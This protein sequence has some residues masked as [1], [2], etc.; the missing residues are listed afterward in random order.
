[1]SR[2]TRLSEQI[3]GNAFR[4]FVRGRISPRQTHQG[5]G[6][7]RLSPCFSRALAPVSAESRHEAKQFFITRIKLRRKW[8]ACAA[9]RQ[10]DETTGDEHGSQHTPFSPATS[11]QRSTNRS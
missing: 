3:P 10:F 7:V 1:M 8:I 11:W 5:H 2:L 9:R 6:F 4:F